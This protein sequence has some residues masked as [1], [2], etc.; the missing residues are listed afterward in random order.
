M[1]QSTLGRQV[2][3]LELELGVVLF[4]RIGKGIE[5]T[6]AGREL[7]NLVEAMGHAATEFCLW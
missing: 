6:P 2:S 3:A 5:I 4:E 1:T 7:L